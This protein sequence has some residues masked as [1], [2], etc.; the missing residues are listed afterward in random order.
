[1]QTEK[2]LRLIPSLMLA[3]S[4]IGTSFAYGAGTVALDHIHGLSYN[5]D[6]QQLLAGSHHGLIVYADSHWSKPSGPSHDY[7]GFSA[8]GNAI[9]SSGHPAPGSNEVNPMGLIKSLDGGKSWQKIGLSGEADF[10]TLATSYDTN[11]VYVLNHQPNSRMTKAGIYYTLNDGLQWRKAEASGLPSKVNALAVHASDIK[12]VAATT[13][14]GLY[15]SHDSAASFRRLLSGQRTL[16]AAFDPSGAHLWF[17]G[18]AEKATLFKI[19]LQAG[20][21][22]ESVKLPALTKDAVAYIALNP[23]RHGELAVATFNQN[24]YL[25]KN[26]GGTWTQIAREGVAL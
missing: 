26:D 15:L 2:Y 13:D 14:D 1:M 4:A 24:I 22:A 25:S 23:S 21:K 3:L 11:A 7:M 8:T 17:S 10:H 12:V 18:Y 9:Y 5:A 6:G 19:G 20:A 16:A